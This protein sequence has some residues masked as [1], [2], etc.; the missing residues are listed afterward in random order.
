MIC[1]RAISVFKSLKNHAKSL[2]TT[3]STSTNFPLQVDAVI[4]GGGITGCSILYQ[5]A[6]RGVHA[7]L[8]ER[9]KLTCGTTFHTAGLIWSLRPSSLEV[10]VLKRTK[11]V[12]K[13]LGEEN[14]GWINNGSLFIAH[15]ND[16]VNEFI[17]LSEFG[18]TFGVESYILG[19]K[20]T[21]ELFPLLNSRT[22]EAALHSPGIVER[23]Y[24]FFLLISH[25][26][27]IR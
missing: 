4:I 7:A 5:L 18:K 21:T 14:C 9:G 26:I 12:F 6:K 11:N 2:S 13:E 27:T 25:E 19:A 16:E 20:E 3:I 10:E 1:S 8:I 17:Q 22:F 24:Y 23:S 15:S